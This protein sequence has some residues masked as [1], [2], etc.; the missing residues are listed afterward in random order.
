ML[1]SGYDNL[2]DRLYA[3]SGDPREWIAALPDL[4]SYVGGDVGQLVV[5]NRDRL[6]SS[7]RHFYAL[8]P[9]RDVQNIRRI[10]EE[11]GARDPRRAIILGNV[12]RILSDDEIEPEGF[13]RTGI[14]ADYLDRL[15]VRRH[16]VCSFRLPGD[17]IATLSVMRSRRAGSFDGTGRERMARAARHLARS[18]GIGD[19]LVER[20]ACL[21]ALDLV[22][23]PLLIVTAAGRLVFGNVTGQALMAAGHLRLRNGRLACSRPFD[24]QRLDAAIAL[25]TGVATNGT[26]QPPQPATWLLEAGDFSGRFVVLPLP[27][28]HALRAVSG[29]GRLAAVIA[30]GSAPAPTE[31]LRQL[32]GLTPSEARL[33]VALTDGE[34]LKSAAE[35]FGISLNTARDQLKSL[36][37]KMNVDRQSGLVLAVRLSSSLPL[38]NQA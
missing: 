33:A 25:A 18:F 36:F 38:S 7:E 21:G 2:V 29:P 31:R 6:I 11:Y 30:L 3:G 16:L 34:T 28:Q 27:E 9:N 10:I 1:D 12:G 13:E 35:H 23:A 24:Q 22:A 5:A 32:Y 4:C 26:T 37:R 19:L 8:T 15:D 17:S 20:A 14:V